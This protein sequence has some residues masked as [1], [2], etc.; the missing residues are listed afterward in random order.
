MVPYLI[1]RGNYPARLVIV[2]GLA[3]SLA[4]AVYYLARGNPPQVM[5][6][7]FP[8]RAEPVGFANLF[9]SAPSFLYTLAL[10]ILIGM[11]A[12]DRR[13]AMFH[14]LVWTLLAL[15]L[16]I[17]QHPQIAAALSSRLAGIL[18]EPVWLTIGPYWSRGVFDPLDL[19]ATLAG[20]LIA[21]ALLARLPA[22]DSDANA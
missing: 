2:A 17:S 7:L 1:T 18:P 14:C 20:G 11:A 15:L 8:V 6:T 12:A 19:A 22:Q 16:E 3:L 21:L 10:A 13:R 4:I 5:Q 9:A